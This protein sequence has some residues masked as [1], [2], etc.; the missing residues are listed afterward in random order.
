MTLKQRILE[1][2]DFLYLRTVDDAKEN[3]R[4]AYQTALSIDGKPHDFK[5]SADDMFNRVGRFCW[6]YAA[7][8]NEIACD[9]YEELDLVGSSTG[10][11]SISDIQHLSQEGALKL[12]NITLASHEAD[13]FKRD[14][15]RTMMAWAG[16]S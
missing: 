6:V 13:Q 9:V 10:G 16:K 7:T 11:A 1:L 12:F 5:E 4:N 2:P 14:V 3:V 8:L 15:Q